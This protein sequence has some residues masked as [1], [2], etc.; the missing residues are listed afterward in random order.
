MIL[1]ADESRKPRYIIHYTGLTVLDFGV[2]VFISSNRYD[3]NKTDGCFI[4]RE[5][6]EVTVEKHDGKMNVRI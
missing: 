4:F 1:C 3:L 5:A 2:G 6:E